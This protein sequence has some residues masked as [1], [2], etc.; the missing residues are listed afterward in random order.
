ML[1]FIRSISERT[2][3]GDAIKF[4]GWISDGKNMYEV[5]FDTEEKMWYVKPKNG[6]TMYE[7]FQ[8]DLK[9]WWVQDIVLKEPFFIIK[10]DDA[11]VYDIDITSAIKKFLTVTT[12]IIYNYYFLVPL[13]KTIVKKKKEGYVFGGF[14][15]GGFFEG[16]IPYP[17]QHPLLSWDC[18]PKSLEEM[19]KYITK[20]YPPDNRAVAL[21]NVALAIAKVFSPAVRFSTNHVFEDHIVINTHDVWPEKALLFK[22][23][24]DLLGLDYRSVRY[25]WGRQFGQNLD[26]KFMALLMSSNAPLFL[27]EVDKQGLRVILRYGPAVA[28]ANE[29]PINV[30]VRGPV[31]DF[32]Y[33]SLRSIM[34]NTVL[35][36]Q[37]LENMLTKYYGNENSL[38]WASRW[39][40]ILDWKPEP[41][42]C[43]DEYVGRPIL[44]CL[45][46]L[47]EDDEFRARVLYT[48]W[49]DVDVAV[50]VMKAMHEK[51][52]V[53]TSM[54][55]EAVTKAHQESE[56]LSTHGG[57]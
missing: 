15:G 7:V 30:K 55:I 39:L 13:L 42:R 9:A 51:Y 24:I 50:M 44:N 32:R 31:I 57:P 54:Y 38:K 53:D 19:A 49:S 12:G 4:F 33:Y 48:T 36:R 21:A 8:G 56:S 47:W 29:T 43:K 35:D 2:H 11:V 5:R 22:Y 16:L 18:Y 46:E 23:I 41:M 20:V 6:H 10:T 37:S 25:V 28:L 34:V 40:L 27:D 52:G 17:V 45:R 14:Y 1:L 26:E 3:M